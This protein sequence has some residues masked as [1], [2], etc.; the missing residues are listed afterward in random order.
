MSRSRLIV[1]GLIAALL[2]YGAASLRHLD[3]DG[4]LYVFDSGVLPLQARPVAPGWR[5]VPRLLAR[6]ASYPSGRTV[7]RAALTG[8]RAA[9]SREGARLE[10][11]AEL[12][13]VLDPQRLLVLHGL[14]GP[15]Y[16]EDWLPG[17][18]RDATQKTVASVSYD[19]IRTRDPQVARAVREAIAGPLGAAGLRVTGLRVMQVAGAGE[20]SGE[21]LRLDA[22]PLDRRVVLI[23]VDSF[24]WRIIDPLIRRGTMPNLA[25]LVE[26]GTRANLKT[27]RPI[28]SPVIWTSIATGMKPSRHGIVDFVV[29]ARDTGAMVPVTS[30]MRQVPALWGLMSRQGVDV[31]VVAWWATW[32]A[33]TVRGAMVTDRVA[34]QL[35]Q[36]R[37]QDDWKSGGEEADRGKTHPPELIEELRPLIVSPREIDDAEVAS[38]LGR[39]RLPPGMSRE[40]DDLLNDF[41]TV[42]AGG[43]TYHAIARRLLA[44][45]PTPLS[46]FYYQGPDEASHL[47][48]RYRPPLLPGTA[49]ADMEL[50]G[51]VV[52]R[53]YERQD[54]YI[55]E[56]VE[57][58]GPRA[59][60]MVVS[61]HGFKSDI[62]RPPHSD[63]RI[64]GGDAADWHTPIGMLLMAGPDVRGGFDLGAASILDVAPTIL[65]LYGLPPA[66]DMDGQPLTEA[67]IPA[68]TQAH[69]VAWIDSYGGV[70]RPPQDDL[71]AA[72]EGDAEVLEK[73]RN[74][75]Y[76]GEDRTTAHNNRGV[77]ALDEGDID[78]AIADFERAL[79]TG[80]ATTMAVTNL[81]RAW[82]VKGDLDQARLYAERALRDKPDNKQAV[83][84]LGGVEMK[85][86]HA[87]LA[88]R[89]LRRAIT[90]DPTFTQARSKLGELLQKGGRDDEA[91]E[92]FRKV[93]EIAP[94][95]PVEF[96]NIGNIH[97]KRR[98][99]DKA[100]AAYREALRCDAQYIG[101]YNNL[102]LCLQETGKLDEARALYDRALVIRPENPYLRNSMG[103]L[104][105]L[106]GDRAAAILEF[107][108]A[109]K[110]DPDWPIAQGNLA[111]LLFETGRL[112]EALQAFERWITTEP[113]SVEPRLGFALASLMDSSPEKA[114]A[115]FEEVLKLDPRNFRAHVALGETL[116][117]RGDLAAAQGHLETAAQLEGRIPRVYNSLGEIY[118]RRGLKEQAAGA[119]RRSLAIEPG[120]EEIRRRLADIG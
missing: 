56:I 78:G 102:G 41:R 96:N 119:Y 101:A 100:M 62:N 52:E 69:P 89:H 117:R 16:A 21:I 76:I 5:F 68:F 72:S 53:Y 64:G 105:A 86:G 106:Q 2:L 42:I 35:F 84:L 112:A 120:Q 18:L 57:A 98:Q 51:G 99:L 39:E 104:L 80:D 4:R 67:F 25:R 19:L 3:D 107:E 77:I 17:L 85:A 43:K 114:I 70:R 11:E 90:L 47:F 83:L 63:P 38:F 15:R 22:R 30:A 108:R 116:L 24:D 28:L 1:A 44:R 8:E 103:T 48:M 93:I 49:R 10:I 94:L 81:A 50:L 9:V 7:L 92:Q 88:E 91:L 27:I 46:M 111:T 79:A 95:S 73:L 97:R 34:Y 71:M 12:D 115:R 6:V 110:A 31:N 74:L 65:A 32:P 20:T 61:D 109:V 55:G 13:C 45:H 40:Q 87:D 66:R 82:L 23:G 36:D 113:E 37:V 54:R 58:A 75:G 59:T 29:T 60:I 118:L 14:H 33:E 26:R